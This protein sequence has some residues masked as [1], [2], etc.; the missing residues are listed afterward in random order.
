MSEIDNLAVRT[1]LLQLLSKPKKDLPHAFLFSGSRGAGKTTAA[2]LIAKLFNC[3]KSSKE[4][5][6]CGSCKQCTSI[7]EG[8]NLDVLE[9]DAASNR[10]I[11]EIRAL[12]DAINLAPV[13]ADF[14]IYIIDEV[15]MLTTEAFNAL[16][17]TLEE[18]PAHAV[19]ILATTDPQKVPVTIK[20]RCVSLVFAK[21]KIPELE[22][23]LQRI[24]QKEKIPI[25][26]AAIRKIAG[27]V[28]GSFRDGVKYLEQVSF[29]TGPITDEVVQKLFSLSSTDSISGFIAS[30]LRHDA[31]NALDVVETLVST[32]ADMKVFITQCLQT[33]ESTMV[34]HVKQG[35]AWDRDEA[36]RMIRKLS[37]AYVEM[38]GAPIAQLP[39]ELAV[40]EFCQKSE[41]Y[42]PVA[43]APSP[44]VEVKKVITDVPAVSAPVGSLTLEKLVDHWA[45]IIAELKPYNHSVAGVMRST[46][47][48]AVSGGIVVIEAFYTFHK[49]KL[50][51][52]KTK[53]VLSEVLKKLFGEK[54]KVEVVLGKK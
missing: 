54:V 47:P 7:A 19:F 13:S 42:A 6:P 25:D 45:D 36:F 32:G 49:D 3:E 17:K 8:N 14:R 10:G 51:E 37:E 29:H 31:L 1:E 24:A 53:D 35:D 44:Q 4:S 34:S 50:S 46:R 11:D 48:K 15:H 39:L 18:P 23:A 9:I 5:G 2:R 52:S 30:M 16:L 41:M 33:L 21:A 26:E 12:R 20:S 38:R 22:A 27:S 43:V 40:V 28:D